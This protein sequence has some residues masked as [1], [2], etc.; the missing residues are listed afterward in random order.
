MAATSVFISHSSS[1]RQFVESV[2]L[3]TLKRAGIECWYSP[4]DI[5]CAEDWERSILAGLEGTEWFLLVMSPRAQSSEWVRDEVMWAVEQ[6]MGRIVPVLIETCD[7]R[8]IHIRLARIQH[9]DLRASTDDGV[10]SLLSILLGADRGPGGH[11]PGGRKSA[12][13]SRLAPF[14][15]GRRPDVEYSDSLGFPS[16]ECDGARVLMMDDRF[17]VA[18]LEEHVDFADAIDF[19]LARRG[20]HLEMLSPGASLLKALCGHCS[21]DSSTGLIA[22]PPARLPYV[23][24]LHWI[25]RDS[26]FVGDIELRCLADP[27]VLGISDDPAD[28]VDDDR[29]DKARKALAQCGVTAGVADTIAH[30][31]DR[32]LVSWANVMLVT[33]AQGDAEYRHLVRM[34]A[35]LQ[36]LWYRM[37]LYSAAIEGLVERL[38]SVD[39]KAVRTDVLKTKLQYAAFCKV[40]ATGSTH[41][42]D[43]KASLIKTSKLRELYDEFTLQAELIDELEALA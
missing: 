32:Y 17:G 13:A 22:D 19:L 18:L 15:F 29:V 14:Y 43:L 3:P 39:L 1:D 21:E 8:S 24:S 10:Q 40:D 28:E 36:H 2:I 33:G 31:E 41:L 27:C 12:T 16:F 6:R 26:S 23:M 11:A 20:R 30:G 34:E 42:N 38:G 9:V 37:H 4:D 7:P 25:D 35:Q 5:S